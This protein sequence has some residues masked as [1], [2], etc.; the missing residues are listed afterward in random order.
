[1]FAAIFIPDF[2]LQSVLR[3][4]P[5]LRERSVALVDPTP[6]K[7]LI[8]QST[9]AAQSFGVCAGLTP[10]QAMARCAGLIIKACSLA[11]E[12]SATEVLLQTAYAFSPNCESTAPGVCTMELKGLNFLSNE[13][14]L[15]EWAKA[16][17]EILAQ[18]YL[19]AKIGFAATPELALLAARAADPFLILTNHESSSAEL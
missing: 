13:Q 12:E 1:M 16:I 15:E 17:C 3:H 18:F 10:S 11:Q 2:S 8:V 5:E 9:A 7:P 4:E 6:A 19:E 14:A